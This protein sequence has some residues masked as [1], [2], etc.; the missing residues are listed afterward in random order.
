MVTLFPFRTTLPLFKST[1]KP[2]AGEFVQANTVLLVRHFVM[3]FFQ[4]LLC[5]E[6]AAGDYIKTTPVQDDMKLKQ[7]P[8]DFVVKE[9]ST[10]KPEKEGPYTYF[11][12]KKKNC[13]TLQAMQ[14][15]ATALKVPLKW[16]ACAGNKDKVALTEQVCSVATIPPQRI[17][18][19]KLANIELKALG[20]GKKPASLGDL[21]GNEFEIIVR[22]IEHLPSL[23]K[24]FINYFGEQRFSTNNPAIGKAIVKKDFK[25]AI[26]LILATKTPAAKKIHSIL[27]VQPK[28]Y[29]EA[30]KA[31][32]TKLLKLY[33]HAYQSLLWNEL[34]KKYT[35]HH[36][37]NTKLPVPGFATVPDN[38]LEEILKRE[39][40]NLRDFVIKEFPS[41]SSEGTLRNVFAEVH[42]LHI[43]KLED[44][45][46]NPGK[47]KV[48]LTFTLPPGSYA[49]EFIKQLF[50]E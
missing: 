30:L 37:K 7:Q 4:P 35:E 26:A 25:Q 22:D 46:L 5:R 27:A 49:T 17:N 20:K 19:L 31:L 2:R 29:L 1:L 34:A 14:Q 33:I 48:K 23:K 44:D 13:T 50:Q 40:V 15:I 10:V 18:E 39:G 41:L 38:Q 9:I 36:D 12:L 32:P 6:S 45:E 43:G 47:K 28:N 21:K 42:D 3:H 8:E 24:Q 11:L 16:I